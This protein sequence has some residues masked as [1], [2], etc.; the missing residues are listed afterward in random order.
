MN[1]HPLPGHRWAQVTTNF[2]NPE[3]QEQEALLK[4]AAPD[5]LVAAKNAA[6]WFSGL[7]S[8]EGQ[9]VLNTLRAAMAKAEGRA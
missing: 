6:E 5:L 7:E 2:S 4:N 9:A 8:A 1:G 3:L